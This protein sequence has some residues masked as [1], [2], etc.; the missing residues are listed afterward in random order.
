M[1]GKHVEWRALIRERHA[2]TWGTRV[3]YL[4][5]KRDPACL[6]SLFLLV[7]PFQ[8]EKKEPADL[9]AS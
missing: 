6:N 3:H 5:K 9:L 1:N 7:P 2:Q 8:I 4:G